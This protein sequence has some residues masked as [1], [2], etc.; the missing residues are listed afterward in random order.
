MGVKHS[1]YICGYKIFL[2]QHHI[3]PRAKGGSDGIENVIAL[4]PN[5]HREVHHFGFYSEQELLELK[6]KKESGPYIKSPGGESSR[7]P[8][9]HPYICPVDRLGLK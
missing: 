1:C 6:H 3:I 4:C 9:H 7:Y 8:L 5:C 2:E